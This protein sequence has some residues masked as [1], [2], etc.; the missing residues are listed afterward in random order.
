MYSALAFA[1][2]LPFLAAAVLPLFGL[3][4]IGPFGTAAEL[5]LV[6]L[7]I[8]FTCLLYVDSRLLRIGVIDA[9]YFR[10]RVAATVLVLASLL[11]VLSSL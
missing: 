11:L 10:L 8:A 3:E 2:A 1:G 6:A 7:L 9:D 5:A 4:T